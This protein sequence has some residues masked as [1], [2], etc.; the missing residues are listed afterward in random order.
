MAKPEKFQHPTLGAITLR[1]SP[2]ARRISISVRPGGQV[3]LTIPYGIDQRAA[4]SF[5]DRKSEWVK[6]TLAQMQERFP[7]Q[8]IQPP[9]ST[10]HH[11]L[12][13]HPCAGH[14]IRTRV[15]G[16]TIEI[17][18]PSGLRYDAEQVQDAIRRGI[19]RAW[20]IEAL[21]DLPERTARLARQFGFRYGL[22]TVRNLHT[23]WGSCSALNHISL[24]IQL[25]K[26]PDAL[27]DYV[28]IHELCHTIHKNHGP[29][30][31][32]LLDCLT[33]GHHRELQRQLRNYSVRYW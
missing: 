33:E 19:E 30:F 17:C 22:V 12:L 10:R 4:L 7:Q 23:R 3:L 27:I 8:L 11:T 18:C 29:E 6:K 28:I 26:L 32:K 5:L 16:D 14:T 15:R 20:H 13:L 25:M 24:N 31:H 9:Y 1:F 21:A 2:R